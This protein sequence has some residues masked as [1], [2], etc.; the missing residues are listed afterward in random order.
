MMSFCAFGLIVALSDSAGGRDQ[1]LANACMSRVNAGAYVATQG[2]QP[3]PVD[4]RRGVA[5][6]GGPVGGRLK[7]ATDIVLATVALVLLA[8]LF[9]VVATLL[10]L[11]L[12]RPVFV[13]RQR[14]GFAGRRFTVYAFSTAPTDGVRQLTGESLF[15]PCAV[16]LLRDSGLDRLPELIS[17]LRGDMSFVGPRPIQAG[18]AGSHRPDYLAARPGL[19]DVFRTSRPGRWG[20]RRRAA[21]DRYYARRWTIW[22]DLAA[23]ARSLGDA[24]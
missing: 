8:P 3:G 10:H 18:Y 1:L 5:L 4:V 14:V 11:G 13:A 16:R 17:V 22:L 2:A 24:S 19:I 12:G 23:L 21:M 20:D 6:R 15:T 7:R 9:L